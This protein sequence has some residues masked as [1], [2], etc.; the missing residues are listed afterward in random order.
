MVRPR[1]VAAILVAAAIAATLFAPFAGAVTDNTGTQSVT[2][3]SV[4]AAPAGEVASLGGYDLVSG[5]ETVYWYNSSSS[6]YEQVTA[7]TDYEINEE[8]GEIKTLSGGEI[9]DGDD[10]KVTY[11]YEATGSTTTSVV[12]V[13]PLLLALLVLVVL[14]KPIMEG[15]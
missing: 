9:S 4:T 1:T 10:L 7:G 3:E 2:N 11:D 8:P 12:T 5:S 14:S 15:M 13:A 6:S